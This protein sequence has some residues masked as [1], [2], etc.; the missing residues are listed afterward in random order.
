MVILD[1]SARLVT[2]PA[3]GD[4]AGRGLRALAS[5]IYAAA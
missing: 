5:G 2:H 3:C 1:S 4:V